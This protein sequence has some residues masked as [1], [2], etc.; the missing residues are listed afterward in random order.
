MLAEIIRRLGVDAPSDELGELESSARENIA[1]TLQKLK[2]RKSSIP[3]ELSDP[4][5]TVLYH[6]IMVEASILS[7]ELRAELRELTLDDAAHILLLSALRRDGE[8]H[9][10]APELEPIAGLDK[11]GL[12]LLLLLAK[13]S[14]ATVLRIVGEA[15]LDTD[16]LEV[17]S[18]VRRDEERHVDFLKRVIGRDSISGEQ[19]RYLKTLEKASHILGFWAM[20]DKDMQEKLA[21][22]LG[23]GNEEA[24]VELGMQRLTLAQEEAHTARVNILRSIGFSLMN[25]Q[26]I[27]ELHGGLVKPGWGC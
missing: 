3:Q 17:V 6:L 25:A 16:A 18:I 4:F 24:R 20:T 7:L 5:N 1:A 12:Q 19:G 10:N 23:G 14:L 8:G 22:L 2:E 15:G 21:A 9:V 26:K 27:S 13:N 11:N